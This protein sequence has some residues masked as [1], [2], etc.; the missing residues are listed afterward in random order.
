ML[1]VQK[2]LANR[3]GLAVFLMALV[4]FLVVLTPIVLAVLTI[5][6]NA[7]NI[8]AQLRSFYLL[9]LK[10]PPHWVSH[11]PLTG[12]KMAKRWTAFAALG[13]EERSA[14]V[15]PYVQRALRWFVGKAGGTGLVIVDFL[16]TMIVAIILYA[17]GETARK[18]VLCF[19]RRLAGKRGEE[20][21]LLAGKAVRGVVLGVVLTALTQAAVGGIGLMLAGVPAAGL[22]AAMTFIL[23]LAQLGPFLVLVPAVVWLYWSGQAV[24]GTVLLVFTIVAGTVDNFLR[25]FLIKKGADLPLLL[26]FAGVIGGLIA[27]GVVGLFIAPVILGIAYTL[28]RAWVTDEMGMDEANAS[29]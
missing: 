13:P 10:G 26:I 15:T 22:L 21:A 11:I 8:A 17:N 16:L 14:L 27:F 1:R 28:L 23:C 12:Q 20:V 25:P 24:S 2:R 5:T 7:D 9:S 4:L 29:T 3:R 19:A 6:K 18:G